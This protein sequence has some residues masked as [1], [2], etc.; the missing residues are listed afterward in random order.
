M[1]VEDEEDDMMVIKTKTIV[2]EDDLKAAKKVKEEL[3]KV[4]NLAQIIDYSCST[5]IM[6]YGLFEIVSIVKLTVL[7]EDGPVGTREGLIVG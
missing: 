7:T 5:V 2:L 6:C 1:E 4:W 3:Q